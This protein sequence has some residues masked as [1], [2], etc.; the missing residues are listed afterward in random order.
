MKYFLMIIAALSW[1]LFTAPARDQTPDALK[2][3]KGDIEAARRLRRAELNDPIRPTWHF[4]IPEAQGYPFDPNGAFF[5][6]GVYHLLCL[7]QAE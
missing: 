2:I 4:T 6:D 3:Q 7:Y 1:L 5:K